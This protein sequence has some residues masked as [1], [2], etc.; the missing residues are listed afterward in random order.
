MPLLRSQGILRRGSGK[1]VKA[2]EYGGH[3]SKRPYEST[4]QDTDEL[5]ETEAASPEFTRV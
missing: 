5:T 1:N 4:N 3:L 2:R